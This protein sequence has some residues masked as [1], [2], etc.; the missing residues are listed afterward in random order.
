RLFERVYPVGAKYGVSL[1]MAGKNTYEVAMFR[2]DGAYEDGRRPVRVE[3]S[4]EIEDVKRR[5]FTINALIYDPAEDRIIDHVGGVGDIRNRII[6]TVGDPSLRISEDRLRMLRAVRFAARFG[7]AIEPGTM[8]AIRANARRIPS[9]SCERIGEELSKMFTGQHPDL[10]LTLLDESGLLEQVLPE[11]AAMKGVEQAPEYHPEGDVFEHT[12]L[13]LKLFG[14]GSPVMAFAV[15]L[16]DVGKPPTFSKTDRARFNRHDEI[17]AEMA[18]SILRRLRFSGETILRVRDLV[19]KHMH[20]LN[21]P[22]MRE[23]TLRRFM[24]Q[25]DFAEL[26]ELHR[27]DCLASHCDLS[28]YDFLKERMERQKEEDRPLTLPPTLIRG[29]DLI[30]LGIE[31][32]PVFSRILNEALDAQL[33]GVITSKSEALA[34]VRERYG[35]LISEKT[36]EQKST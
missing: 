19:R 12:R 14:G 3:R 28:A 16:H 25:P 1:V 2:K 7:F 5:D 11:V 6:R 24:A 9:V 13:M 23:S 27:L 30:E 20:F 17:G 34:W 26:L 35:P 29:D 4:D 31:P 21:V 36:A 8:E 10:S 32:G 22:K 18:E 15:L 33:E